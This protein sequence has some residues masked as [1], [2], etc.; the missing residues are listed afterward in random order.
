MS[1]TIKLISLLLLISLEIQAQQ[2]PLSNQYLMNQSMLNPA[3]NGIHDMANITALTRGQWIGVEGAPYTH[4]L[5]MASTISDH[6]AAGFLFVKDN[7]G[8]NSTT[9]IIASYAYRMDLY[10]NILSFGLQGGLTSYSM[11][12]NKLDAQ[13][14]GDPAIG[15]GK[16]TQRENTFGFGMMY[17]TDKYYIG[18]ASPRMTENVVQPEGI[19][20][21]KYL[22]TYNLSAGF[23]VTPADFFKIKPSVLIR[24]TKGDDL[25][26]D[27][28]GQ[29][30][31]NEEFWLGV[32][33]RNL[34]TGGVNIIYTSDDI[35]HFGYSFNFPFTEVG[36]TGYGTHELMIS[37]DM[38][39][40]TRHNR[41]ERFF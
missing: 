16:Y 18:V 27:L 21:S 23:I 24:Y 33:I 41:A 40:I 20:V 37:I 12:F 38:K 14:D 10:G 19:V 13:V 25:A 29:I 11:N 15:E 32:S 2:D 31:I 6:S 8:I 7:F 39:L 9:H 28:N 36:T 30:L 4:T 35:Y 26:I 5:S 1:K 22:P 17:K 34:N 3:Y